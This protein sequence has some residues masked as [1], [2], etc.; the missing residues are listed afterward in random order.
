MRAKKFK[1]W[2]EKAQVWV[3][4]TVG[5]IMTDDALAIYREICRN[6]GIWYQFTGLLDKNGKEIYE[7]DVVKI[8]FT[9]G[10]FKVVVNYCSFDVQSETKQY[11]LNDIPNDEIEVIGNIHEK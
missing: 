9:H 1:A 8:D 4:F 2:Y 10:T 6:G 11:P 3:Y 5:T 7:G